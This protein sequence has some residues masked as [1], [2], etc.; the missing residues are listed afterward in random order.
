MASF[1]QICVREQRNCLE[2]SKEIRQQ[3]ECGQSVD[4]RLPDG[5]YAAFGQIVFK[6]W[7][8]E[9]LYYF[10]VS[11]FFFLPA[12]H[13]RSVI[14]RSLALEARAWK[15]ILSLKLSERVS[16]ASLDLAGALFLLYPGF[17]FFFF[18]I[19]YACLV[20]HLSRT[21]NPEG[22]TKDLTSSLT[23]YE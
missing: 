19:D 8:V 23:S 6:E 11:L 5:D 22:Q 13:P 2:Q 16:H 20:A 3:R 18:T 17:F 14:T 21:A 10:N 12:Y 7:G 1:V 15:R 9:Y 4:W